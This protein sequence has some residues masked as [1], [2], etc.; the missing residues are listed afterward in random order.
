VFSIV[1]GRRASQ[2]CMNQLWWMPESSEMIASSGSTA[3][4]SATIRSGRIGV[5]WS[6]KFGRMNFSHSARQPA[7][8]ACHSPN[9][10]A[11]SILRFAASARS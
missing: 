10:D 9:C 5:V 11:P 2:N 8:C 7:I 3:R 6:S 1:C 4:Q